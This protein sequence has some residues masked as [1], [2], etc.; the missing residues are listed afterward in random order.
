MDR[1][2]II[3]T[4]TLLLV[5]SF[6]AH[7]NE[8]I[9]HTGLI[10]PDKASTEYLKKVLKALGCSYTETSTP[11]GQRIEWQSKS[12][13]EEQEIQNRVSQY[14]FLKEVCKSK[15][16]PAPSQAAKEKLSCN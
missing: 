9:R 16:L 14:L 2:K 1:R 11:N 8:T 4:L 15:N 6:K 3:T 7:S 5:V 10:Y 13:A 12:E